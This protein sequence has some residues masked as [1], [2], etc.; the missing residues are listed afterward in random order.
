VDST[1]SQIQFVKSLQPLQN[2][3]KVKMSQEQLSCNRI[4]EFAEK[5]L[6]SGRAK[7]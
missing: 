7:S 3:D 2:V 4:V 5:S 1:K 6:K